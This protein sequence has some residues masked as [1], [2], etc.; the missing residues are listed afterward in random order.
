MVRSL[1]R[2]LDIIFFL[3]QHHSATPT[4][5]ATELKVPR[6]TVHRIL[7]TLK[8]KGYVYQHGSDRKFRLTY[9]VLSLS[10]GFSDEDYMANLGIDI[11]EEVT[12]TLIW[13]VSLA[14]ISGVDVIVRNNTDAS[15]KLAVEKY[16]IGYRMP[17][18]KSASG[19]CI[20]AHLTEGE[21]A[22]ILAM[23]EKLG[24]EQDH[25]EQTPADLKRLFSKVAR[26]GYATFRRKRERFDISAIA[27]PIFANNEVH[28]ALTLR[29][30]E[31]ALSE[32]ETSTVIV[33]MLQDAAKTFTIQLQHHIE[34][35]SENK[36]V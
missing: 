36:L 8:E 2:G 28:G 14:T 33:P 31:P 9:R 21:R 3:N 29:Y 5:L 16:K 6:A 15:S 34:S 17:I 19:I 18:L 24:R 27:V 20:L 30:T 10:Q 23:A 22:D 25:L 13:P 7:K 32:E 4:E 12:R 26:N 1:S 11:M 35:K